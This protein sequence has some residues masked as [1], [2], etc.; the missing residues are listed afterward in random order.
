MEQ[1]EGTYKDHQVQLPDYFRANQKL[2]NVTEDIIRM[3]LEY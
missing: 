2:R 1:L 3:L